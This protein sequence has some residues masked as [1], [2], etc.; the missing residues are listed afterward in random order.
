MRIRL[1]GCARSTSLLIAV[2]LLGCAGGAENVETVGARPVPEGAIA[3]VGAWT[4]NRQMLEAAG[5]SPGD[6]RYEPLFQHLLDDA[7]LASE[8]R[9]TSA[10]RASA[11]ERGVLAR[12]LLEHLAE[13]QLRARPIS[14]LERQQA[15]A[16][17]WQELDRPR[18][19]KSGYAYLP[20]QPLSDGEAEFA[21]MEQVAA[22][23]RGIHE[24]QEFGQRVEEI[25]GGALSLKAT[26]GEAPPTTADRRVVTWGLLETEVALPPQ[27]YFQVAAK[28]AEVLQTSGVVATEAGLFVI[29]ALEIVPAKR[30]TPEEAARVIARAVGAQR[31]VST[32]QRLRADALA[33]APVVVSDKQKVLTRLVWRTE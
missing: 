7:R 24:A 17:L 29:V 19:V 26:L 2:L 22:A 15:A 18:A 21:Y 12:A 23:V 1:A 14:P 20:F 25:D 33:A 27:P 9:T 30:A 3:T 8:S 16:A 31:S 28:L 6:P 32:L 10:G 13:K 11:V 5:M 4:V